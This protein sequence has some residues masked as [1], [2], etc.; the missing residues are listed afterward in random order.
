MSASIK[1]NME[2]VQTLVDIG[3]EINATAKD[4][5]T[6]LMFGA[7]YGNI[8]VVKY[9]LMKGADKSA[10]TKKGEMAVSIAQ[11]KKFNNIV[12]ALSQNLMVE[13]YYRISHLTHLLCIM[14]RY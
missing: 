2:C 12:V 10:V 9:L 11:K 14:K 8:E 13:D 4:G 3:A 7:Y 1:G 5:F 6:A